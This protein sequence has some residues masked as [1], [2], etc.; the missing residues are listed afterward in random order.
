MTLTLVL[1]VCADRKFNFWQIFFDLKGCGGWFEGWLEGG[2][3]VVF[4]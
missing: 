3:G 2:F 4:H 1:V